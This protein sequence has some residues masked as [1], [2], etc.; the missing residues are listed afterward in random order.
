MLGSRTRKF[1]ALATAFAAGTGRF[2]ILPL[3]RGS[4]GEW[5][6]GADLYV[7]SA[8]I[9]GALGW[10]KRPAVQ[11]VGLPLKGICDETHFGGGGVT[12]LRG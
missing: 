11:R 12:C 2:I 10:R 3:T 8:L 4:F 6:K 5:P 7:P 9:E 1:L